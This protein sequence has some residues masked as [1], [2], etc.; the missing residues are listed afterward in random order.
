MSNKVTIIAPSNIAF[1]K[2]WGAIDLDSVLPANVSFSMTLSRCV[3]RTT[4]EARRAEGTNAIQVVDA[5][6][7]LID[8]DPAF[9]TRVEGHLAALSEAL[10]ISG[11]FRVATANTFPSSA[12]IA[13]S[14][15]GFA[16]LATAVAALAGRETSLEEL[17]I[18]ARRSGSGSA[19]RSVMGGYVEW[20]GKADD[21][22]APA[23]QLKPPEHWEL[24]DVIAVVSSEPKLVSS[25]DGHLLAPSSPY[26][27]RRQELLPERLAKMRTAVLER[28]LERLGRAIETEAVELHLVAMSSSPPIFYWKPETMEVLHC[29]WGLRDEEVGAWA[30][31]DAG[32]NVHVI[33]EPHDEE[34][35]VAALGEL[36]GVER[37]IR[38]RV[39]PGPRRS[40]E[41]L[42]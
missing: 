42:F 18:L 2:Y 15:S 27:V 37:L 9:A 35:V 20:P 13:S 10:G 29:V 17:S 33:C 26:F 16:A 39:G 22:A 4:V 25:R 5:S 23:R 11:S 8:A 28:D 1:L 34:R 40:D 32:P 36:R 21:A 31:M 30:T 38:D 3:S 19:A 7:E 41:H 6:G 12:G 24:R 14:A